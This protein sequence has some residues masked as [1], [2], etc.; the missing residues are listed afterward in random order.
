MDGK[1]ATDR[2]L[3]IQGEKISA[4]IKAAVEKITKRIQKAVQKGKC[5]ISLGAF[6]PF[7]WATLDYDQRNVIIKYLK[8]MGFN[9]TEYGGGASV[10]SWKPK[11]FGERFKITEENERLQ[12]VIETGHAP[13]V[14]I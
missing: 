10:I 2:W 9:I 12:H 8:D 14:I 5:Q 13:K 6:L 1:Q 7:F 3:E 11:D 4:R